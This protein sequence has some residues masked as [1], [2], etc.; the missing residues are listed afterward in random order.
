VENILEFSSVI[1]EFERTSDDHSLRA[2][3][4]QVALVTDIDS[5]EESEPAVTLMTLHSAKGLEFSAVFLVGLEE[6]VFPH[7][8]SMQSREELEEERRLCY[9]GMTRAKDELCLSHAYVRTLFGMRQKQLVSRFLREIPPEMFQETKKRAAASSL[10]QE[11]ESA[12][13]AKGDLFQP[14]DRV[15]HSVFGLGIVESAEPTGRDTL[16]I[17][18]FEEVGRKKLLLSFAGLEKVEDW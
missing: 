4:E 15:K 1:E 6:G 18:L 17:V 8:R 9:V 5:Y 11:A 10:W 12:S 16:V 7:I 3:L 2:F 13:S 14:G